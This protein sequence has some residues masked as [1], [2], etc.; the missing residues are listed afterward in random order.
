MEYNRKK[1]IEKV[2]NNSK[3]LILSNK[4][5]FLWRTIIFLLLIF[6]ITILLNYPKNLKL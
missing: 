6:T 1:Q 5:G 4:W 2:F 3:K